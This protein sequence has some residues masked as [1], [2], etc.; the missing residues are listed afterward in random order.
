MNF[1]NDIEN[2]NYREGNRENSGVKNVTQHVD[3]ENEK[4]L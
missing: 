3:N 4:K 1:F 2:L